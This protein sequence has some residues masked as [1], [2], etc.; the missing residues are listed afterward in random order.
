MVNSSPPTTSDLVIPDSPH[1][2]SAGDFVRW[3]LAQL[4]LPLCESGGG[5]NGVVELKLP[6]NDQASFEGQAT[7]KLSL[8][9]KDETCES[10]AF[11]GR[12]GKWLLT[13]LQALGPAAPVR[14]AI[15]PEA[16]SNI[17]QKL[18]DAYQVDGGNVHLGGC[19][20]TDHPFLRLSFDVKTDKANTKQVQHI[21]VA[22]DGSMVNDQLIH[23]LGLMNVKPILRSPPRI[24]AA[25]LQSL[26]TA[27]RRVAAQSTTS[28]DPN[29]TTIEPLATALVWAKQVCGHL[30][31]VIGESAVS[32]SFSGWAKLLEAQPY[33]SPETGGSSF[34]LAATDD[35]R[36]DTADQIAT[37][38]ASGRHVLK[39]ELVTCNT[40][41]KHVLKEFTEPCPVSGKPCLTEQF[42][43]CATCQERVSNQVI[44][45][46]SCSACRK[47]TKVPKDDPRLVW[48]FGEHPGLDRWKHWQLAETQNVYIA[49]AN[50][51]TQRLLVVI[52]K[53]SMAIHHLATAGK[54]SSTWTVVPESNQPEML[55]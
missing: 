17:T 44:E 43:V 23:D 13:R 35:G 41:G 24:D 39:Q 19:Q 16:V 29:A 27:G 54:M 4:K 36:I 9:A 3:A 48:I 55:Q 22:H 11:D 33:V 10:I 30:E 6:E 52:D 46:G 49:Q 26:I 1:R 2:E 28:R 15:Q 8:D 31:F 5:S 38:E 40:T 53:E 12:F 21:F 42:A 14:P 45:G 32:L 20:L 18:F 47:L 7:L 37:C 51:W 34:H 50:G 25:A